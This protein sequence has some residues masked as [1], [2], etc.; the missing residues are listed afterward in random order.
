M[1]HV[2]YDSYLEC[3]LNVLYLNLYTTWL[4][5][6]P[7]GTWLLPALGHFVASFDSENLVIVWWILV[8]LAGMEIFFITLFFSNFYL[9]S[10]YMVSSIRY[11]SNIMGFYLRPVVYLRYIVILREFCHSCLWSSFNSVVCSHVILDLLM[12]CLSMVSFRGLSCWS[13]LKTCQ[14][15]LHFHEDIYMYI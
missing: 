8:G 5:M 2:L 10:W 15:L 3:Y 7:K 12:P 11:G 1:N 13:F 9:Q 6:K 4:P 14:I